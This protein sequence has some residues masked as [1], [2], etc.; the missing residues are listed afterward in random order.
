MLT[1]VIHGAR[2]DEPSSNG[3]H[4][5]IMQIVYKATQNPAVPVQVGGFQCLVRI[6]ALYKIPSYMELDLF[7]LTVMVMH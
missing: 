6:M 5:Y 1:A 7:R 2:Q 3:E 4:N